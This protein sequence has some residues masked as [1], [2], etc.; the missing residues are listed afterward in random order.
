MK[1]FVQ[2]GDVI[3]YEIPAG[4]TIQPGDP[5]IIEDLAGVAAEGGTTG[6]VI[7]VN[8]TG[9]FDLPKVASAQTAGKK[10]Y[11]TSSGTITET[12]GANDEFGWI[13]EDAASGDSYV[14]VKLKQ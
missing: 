7:T 13:F 4:T 2:R 10:A 8:L 3:E 1:D 11:L 5:V 12:S 9:V 6:D 14:A